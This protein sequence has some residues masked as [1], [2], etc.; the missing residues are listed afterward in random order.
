M[1]R[2]FDLSLSLIME[3]DVSDHTTAVVLL[4]KNESLTFMSKKMIVTEQN[5][6]ITEK[7]MLTIV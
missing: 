1:I 4:Q 6:G 3:T 7:E 5:Y 2:H